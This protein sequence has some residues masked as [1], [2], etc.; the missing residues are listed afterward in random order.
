MFGKKGVFHADSPHLP[1]QEV[2]FAG[3]FFGNLRLFRRG[4]V[5]GGGEVIGDNGAARGVK[6]PHAAHFFKLPYRRGSCDVIGKGKINRYFANISGLY[7]IAG[8]SRNDGLNECSC[9]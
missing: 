7:L 8:M 5:L 3:K 1:I 2:L 9:H 4:N 6:D